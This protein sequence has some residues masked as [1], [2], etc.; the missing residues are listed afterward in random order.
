VA[1][2][3]PPDITQR[4]LLQSIVEVARSVFGAAAA[5]VFLLDRTRARLV[6]E[7]VAGEGEDHLVG[8]GFPSDTGI[9]GWVAMSCQPL[10]VDD[11]AASPQFARSSAESTGYVPMSIMAAPLIADGE[12]IGVLEVLDRGSRDRGELG[13]VDLLGLLATEL[14]TAVEL[15]IRLRWASGRPDGSI[16]PRADLLGRLAQRL[17]GAPEPIAT[18]VDQLL[19][20]A[21][22][23]LADQG[24]AAGR[25]PTP[26][27]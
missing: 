18:A 25:A 27:S 3:D 16:T 23:L 4:Q 6:F 7:A 1:V 19:A 12:C 10:L 26:T 24:W 9:A 22:Q 5:S 21:D 11:A 13:D 14:S 20:T 2:N 8:T 17:P 15:L